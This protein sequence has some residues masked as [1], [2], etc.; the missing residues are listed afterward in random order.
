LARGGWRPDAEEGDGVGSEGLVVRAGSYLSFLFC[1]ERWVLG[2]VGVADG[3]T[4]VAGY[5][6]GMAVL[7]NL[8]LVV[9]GDD[10][11]CLLN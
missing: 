1:P 6:V 10:L 9:V 11:F 3:L 4:E 2:A 7:G 8:P 5:F